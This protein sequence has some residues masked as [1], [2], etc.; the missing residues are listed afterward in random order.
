MIFDELWRAERELRK[1]ESL[2]RLRRCLTRSGRQCGVQAQVF[3]LSNQCAFLRTV[4][5]PIITP[6]KPIK[7]EAI[8]AK[9]SSTQK[10]QHLGALATPFGWRIPAPTVLLGSSKSH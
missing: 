1:T 6:S 10:A 4:T 8:G 3:W 5:S 2:Y 7:V 9:T